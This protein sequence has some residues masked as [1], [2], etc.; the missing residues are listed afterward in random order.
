MRRWTITLVGAALVGAAVAYFLDPQNGRRRRAVTRDRLGG[1]ARRTGRRV[2]RK[3][4]KV[5]SDVHGLGQ[6]IAHRRPADT[7]PNDATLAHK[8]ES[9]VL[10][11]PTVDKAGVNVNAEDGVVVL[12]GVVARP[13]DITALEEAARKVPGVREVRNLL[14]LPD[15]IP[16]NKADALATE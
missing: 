3:G 16:P 8:V 6:R 13:E 9:E 1:L 2:A 5:A 10:G 11:R 4:T 12:R 14:H 7:D 15:E